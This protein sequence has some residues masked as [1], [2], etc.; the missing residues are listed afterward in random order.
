MTYTLAILR[1]PPAAHAEIKARIERVNQRGDYNHLF[2]DN[3][4]IDLTHIAVQ[5]DPADEVT[6]DY[7]RAEIVL[8]C[9]RAATGFPDFQ[10]DLADAKRFI[11]SLARCGYTLQRV[12]TD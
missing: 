10:I 7:D 1:I 5:P 11:E 6:P 12:A 2:L 8:S 3:D 4:C 9:L